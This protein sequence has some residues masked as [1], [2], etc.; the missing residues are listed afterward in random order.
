M[1]EVFDQFSMFFS[2]GNV[3]AFYTPKFTVFV[4]SFTLGKDDFCYY[5]GW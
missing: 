4:C 2:N 1:R 3:A 5:I